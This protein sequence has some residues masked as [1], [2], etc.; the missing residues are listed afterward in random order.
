MITDKRFKFYYKLV[1]NLL[2]IL[3]FFFNTPVQVEALTFTDSGNHRIAIEKPPARVVSLVPGITETI[4]ALGAGNRVVGRTYQGSWPPETAAIPVMGGFFSPD[5]EKIKQAKPDMIFYSSLQKK[6]IDKFAG[7]ACAMVNLETGSLSDSYQNIILLG[8]IFGREEEARQLV[9]DIKDEMTLI[10]QKIHKIPEAKRCR[11]MRIMGGETLMTP[12][13]DSFQSEMIRAAGGIAPELGKTGDVVMVT[14]E[15]WVKFNP[16]VIYGCSIDRGLSARLFD[17]PGWKDVDAVKSGRVYFFP[18]DLTCRAATNTGYFV[19]WLAARIYSGEFV[20]SGAGVLEDKI[21]KTRPVEIDLDYIE[22]AKIAYSRI[23]DFTN[24]TL[25]IDFKQPLDIVSTLAGF[26]TDIKTVGNH[27][28]SQP[29]WAVAHRDGIA[30]MTD[31][32]Y[33]TMERSRDT[34]SFMMTGADMDKLSV[35]TAAFKDMR[36]Y[37][38]VTAGVSS[39]ALRTSVDEGNYYEPG[40]I[41]IILMTNMTLSRRAMTRAIIT[42]TE[43]KTAALAD[44]DIRSSFSG[45]RHQATGTGTDNIIVVQGTGTDIDNSGGHTKMGELMAKAVYAGVTE[46]VFKQNGHTPARNVFQRL[47]ERQTTVFELL[48]DMP[49]D[50]VAQRPAFFE[51]VE[52]LLLDPFYAGFIQSALALSDAY[53]KGLVGD[54]GSFE[55]WC[56]DITRD[57]AGETMDELTDFI[58]SDKI[59]TVQKM[60]I[61]ALINGVWI[62]IQA[63]EDYIEN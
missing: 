41:N 26:K 31:R 17:Q 48:T 30:A 28:A 3:F 49:C 1:F 7:S 24:K 14:R 53:E 11:V 12:G 33:R 22:A 54:L 62:K 63:G 4:F 13:S 59:P 9:N 42:A 61:N 47:N 45:I 52:R 55:I 32:I 10:S 2:V 18:C 43:A 36:V 46:A 8:R 38:L 29:C 39:N 20:A 57:I 58:V 25:V 23:Y 40:T 5:L 56:R 16:Q 27:Y 51:G 21:F 35:Q 19:S 50:C 34:A 37:A 15:E 44:L 60:A 6:V